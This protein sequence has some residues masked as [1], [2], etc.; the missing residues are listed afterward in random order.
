MLAAEYYSAFQTKPFS[1]KPYLAQLQILAREYY[2]AFQLF[3]TKPSSN[4]PY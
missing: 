1:N 4:Q 2:S 3:Q